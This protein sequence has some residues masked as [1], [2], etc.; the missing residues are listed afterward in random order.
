MIPTPLNIGEPLED[1]ENEDVWEEIIPRESNSG[2][3]EFIRSGKTS[4]AFKMASDL[5][6]EGEFLKACAL[7]QDQN[8]SNTIE[9]LND[10]KHLVRGA[11]GQIRAARGLCVHQ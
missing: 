8:E 10:S 5:G 3:L 6:G 11:Q 7:R 9:H 1:Q 4:E 2:V